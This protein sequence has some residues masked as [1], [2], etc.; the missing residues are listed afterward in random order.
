[1]QRGRLTGSVDCGVEA[2]EVGQDAAGQ[3]AVEQA[4]CMRLEALVAAQYGDHARVQ[5]AAADVVLR[6]LLKPH[7]GGERAVWLMQLCQL[8][9]YAAL[10]GSYQTEHMLCS[11]SQPLPS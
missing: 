8:R 4:H 6:A 10:Q 9:Q 2:H 7:E 1:M 3:H 11:S 5:Q